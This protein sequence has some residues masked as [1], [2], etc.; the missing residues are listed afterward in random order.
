DGANMNAQVGVT[1]PGTLGADVCHLNLHKTF[2][3]PHGGGGPGVGPICV[4]EHLVPFLPS[5]PIVEVGGEKAIT[6]VSSTPYG[7]ALVC[8][9]SYGYICMLGEEGL[10]NAT[11]TAILNANHMKALLE[12]HFSILYTGEM[13][14]AAHEMIVDP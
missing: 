2:A 4:A 5:N 1:N 6:S 10:T 12:K 13:G 7:S 14:C 8:L 11:K 9:I 3:I